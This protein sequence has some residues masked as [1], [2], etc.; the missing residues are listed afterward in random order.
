MRSPIEKLVMKRQLYYNER[1]HQYVI[2][3]ANIPA[4]LPTKEYEA[5]IKRLAKQFRI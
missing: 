2:A 1:Y 4:G 5:E 3:K